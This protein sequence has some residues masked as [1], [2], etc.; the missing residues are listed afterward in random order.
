MQSTRNMEI[1]V[2]IFVALGIAALLMLS[3]K[4]S[5]LGNL[6]AKQ[7]YTITAQFENIGGLKVKSP[8]K[9]SGV[10]IGRVTDISFDNEYYQAIVTMNIE[11][12]YN[13]IPIDVSAS[14]LTAGLLGEQY[15]GL[16]TVGGDEFLV[17][18]DKIDP[19]LTQSAVIVEKLIGKFLYNM[20]SKNAVK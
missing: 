3:I 19:G 10:L 17:N 4:V 16:D 12:K 8:V 6:F 5:H 1:W 9:M 18:G 15:I 7:G 11:S 14:I 2:G 20:A 13:K